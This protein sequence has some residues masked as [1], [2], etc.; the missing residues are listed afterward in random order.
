[1]ARKVV[2]KYRQRPVE[3]PPEPER[4]WQPREKCE[5]VVGDEVSCSLRNPLVTFRPTCIVEDVQPSRLHASGW[6]VLVKDKKGTNR[7]IDSWY[8]KRINQPD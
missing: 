7:W 1:M 6:K 5:V 2:N 3:R 4:P 8:F